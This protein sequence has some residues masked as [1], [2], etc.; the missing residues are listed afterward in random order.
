MFNLYDL[1]EKNVAKYGSKR[2]H[3]YGYSGEVSKKEYEITLQQILHHT[4]CELVDIAQGDNSEVTE[5]I[6]QEVAA[7]ILMGERE[8]V[9]KFNKCETPY[10][11]LN[12]TYNTVLE[13]VQV[14]KQNYVDID[15]IEEQENKGVTP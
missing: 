11:I 1:V 12:V 15:I 3:T 4:I 8:F 10:A 5:E 14:C 6:F 9:I 13:L 7:M 2:R